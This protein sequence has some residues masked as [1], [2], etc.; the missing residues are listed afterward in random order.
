MR[1]CNRCLG[2]Y[3][4]E[5]FPVAVT[6]PKKVHRKAFC[7]TCDSADRKKVHRLK[8]E[9]TSCKIHCELCGCTGKMHFDHD[10]KKG[11]FR[12]WLCVNCNQ[13]LG[14]FF[15]DTELLRRAIAYLDGNL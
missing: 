3:P 13:G 2:L 10:P 7:K 14:K 8:K 1:K 6:T 5:H 4:L 15:D 11:E 9:A 12:G